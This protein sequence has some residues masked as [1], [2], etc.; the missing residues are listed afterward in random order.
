MKQAIITLFLLIAFSTVAFSSE[1]IYIATIEESNDQLI[2]KEIDL[3]GGPGRDYLD[4]PS[5]GYST[6]IIS[7]KNEKLMAYNFSFDREPIIEPASESL[8]NELPKEPIILQFPYYNNAKK[9][10]ILD[11]T[12]KLKLEIDLS[13]YAR[14]NENGFC[15]FN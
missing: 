5:K 6:K 9:I 12:G 8:N 15:D 2:L 3:I 13:S 1:N 14:C 7:F 4:Q 11:E 10:E